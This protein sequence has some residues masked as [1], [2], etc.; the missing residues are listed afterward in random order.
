MPMAVVY[1]PPCIG[2]AVLGVRVG[3][4]DLEVAVA[5]GVVPDLHRVLRLRQQ[6]HAGP[7]RQCPRP[8]SPAQVRRPG[9]GVDQCRHEPT[10]KCSA[11]CSRWSFCEAHGHIVPIVRGVLDVHDDVLEIVAV[12][13]RAGPERL[14]YRVGVVDALPGVVRL[15]R[16]G[17]EHLGLRDAL[18]ARQHAFGEQH[19]EGEQRCGPRA[20]DA[21][22]TATD[23]R[24][25]GLRAG[26][27]V[28]IGLGALPVGAVGRGPI[29]PRV[30]GS[31]RQH[32]NAGGRP[33]RTRLTLLSDNTG[34]M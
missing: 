4:V 17:H 24:P 29:P 9:G 30:G 28:A 13:V 34:T 8:L 27:R 22:A 2:V 18:T 25:P 16:V 3:R 23:E 31:Q 20:A 15:A 5:I 14:P 6:H 33:V 1:R 32:R 11:R 19:G 26:A 21:G 7:R 10:V 12:H